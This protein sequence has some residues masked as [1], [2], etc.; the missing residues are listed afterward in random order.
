MLDLYSPV[1]HFLSGLLRITR[2]YDPTLECTLELEDTPEIPCKHLSFIQT[3]T[4]K[5]QAHITLNSHMTPPAHSHTKSGFELHV[6]SLTSWL[7]HPYLEVCVHRA[8]SF[9]TEP[10]SVFTATSKTP[11]QGPKKQTATEM[12]NRAA[13]MAVLL[14]LLS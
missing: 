11:L 1:F 12:G 9:L 6:R 4:L 2:E 3:H 5:R 7:T 8:C 10:T 13:E 14:L